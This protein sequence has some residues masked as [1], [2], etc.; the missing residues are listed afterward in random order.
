MQP[1]VT[2]PGLPQVE[3]W[4][5]VWQPRQDSFVRLPCVRE[6][7]KESRPPVSWGSDRFGIAETLGCLESGF[8]ATGGNQG[9]PADN[10]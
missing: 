9:Q 3:A 6:E 10:S 7:G 1:Q 5:K 8:S 2:S 4:W